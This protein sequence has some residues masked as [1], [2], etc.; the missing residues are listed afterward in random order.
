MGV[1]GRVAEI[2][3]VTVLALVV[4]S[5][6][7]ILRASFGAFSALGSLAA[8]LRV[9]LLLCRLLLLVVLLSLRLLHLMLG[10]LIVHAVGDHW[11]LASRG[12]VLTALVDWHGCNW[13]LLLPLLDIL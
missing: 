10:K 6:Y 13:L 9:F 3:L 12:H 4:A 5:V 7:V 8:L 1:E 11:D 2:G